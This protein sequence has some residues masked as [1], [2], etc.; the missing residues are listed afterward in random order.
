MVWDSDQVHT[1]S[2]L[3]MNTKRKHLE[4]KGMQLGP[5]VSTNVF[6]DS[7]LNEPEEG[8]TG[9]TSAEIV[10]CRVIE[11]KVE[12]IQSFKNKAHT[13]LN[14]Y[15]DRFR[16]TVDKQPAKVAPLILEVDNAKW[17]LNKNCW[18]PRVQSVLKEQAIRDFVKQAVEDGVIKESQAKYV[19]QVLL[20]PKKNGTYRFCVDYRALNEASTSNGWPIP[21]IKEMLARLGVQVLS[22]LHPLI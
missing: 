2:T 1:R 3:S 8:I 21:K 10:P 7:R 13:M 18:G 20:T 11:P 6:L 22:S 19:S 15:A 12:G 14:E 16:T 5:I 17:Q 4:E 9:S